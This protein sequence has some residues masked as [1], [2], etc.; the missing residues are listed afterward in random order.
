[1]HVTEP[2]GGECILTGSCSCSWL[3]ED[4]HPAA[5]VTPW[6]TMDGAHPTAQEQ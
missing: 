6:D 4:E 5:E 2:H 3:V 1:M